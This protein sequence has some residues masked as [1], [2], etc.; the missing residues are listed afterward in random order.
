M[1]DLRKAAAETAQLPHSTCE[2]APLQK[3]HTRVYEMRARFWTKSGS[4]SSS[5]QATLLTFL[6]GWLCTTQIRVLS[7][8]TRRKALKNEKK[9]RKKDKFANVDWLGSLGGSR[10]SHH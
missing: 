9:K 2:T 5:P 10:I 8:S 4:L 6:V 1:L 3:A 7:M